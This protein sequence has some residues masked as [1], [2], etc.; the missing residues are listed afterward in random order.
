MMAEARFPYI[1]PTDFEAA[2]TQLAELHVQSLGSLRKG[3]LAAE[4]LASNGATWLRISQR[5]ALAKPDFTSNSDGSAVD[6]VEEPDDEAALS[7]ETAD[8][9]VIVYDVVL[10]PSY[11]V[12]VLYFNVK[13]PGYHYP[14]TMDTLYSHIIPPVYRAEAE[15]A[16][17]LGGITVTDHPFT[18]ALVF[19]VH[20]C[21]TAQVLEASATPNA[22]SPLEYLILWMGS[23][24]RYVGLTLPIEVAA[25]ALAGS[26]NND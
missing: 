7:V 1:S 9:A 17:V 8:R 23:L 14:P 15:N 16:G 4:L 5:L 6:E 11:Q 10:S 21:Q 13:D 3:W 2:C 18:N 12:P 25:R 22:I 26:S 20:P 24:C 19:F